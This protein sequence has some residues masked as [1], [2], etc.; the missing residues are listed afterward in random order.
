MSAAPSEPAPDGDVVFRPLA[1]TDFAR[2]ARWL[3][4]PH[5][6]AFWREP[7]SPAAVEAAYGPLVDGADP[8][9]AFV[10]EL[11]GHPVGY[12][13]RYR[14]ADYPDWAAL[15]GAEAAGIDYLLGD[16]ARVGRGLGPRVVAAFTRSTLARYPDLGA[17]T[18]AVAQDNRRSWRALEKAGFTR[19]FAGVL[20]SGDPSDAGPAYLYVR[21]RGDEPPG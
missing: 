15:V 7:A 2:L 4:E 17:V 12:V 6:A 20:D 5:V 13:Q 1:R 8:T 9:E 10:V 19:V 14:I 3:G 11:D 21:R 16:P 18:V